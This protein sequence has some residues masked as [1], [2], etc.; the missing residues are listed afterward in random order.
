MKGQEEEKSVR[1]IKGGTDV[2]KLNCP[3]D[4]RIMDDHLVE[5]TEEGAGWRG[6]RHR[7]SK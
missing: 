6:V 2:L 1:R 4:Q 7:G 5:E 3:W